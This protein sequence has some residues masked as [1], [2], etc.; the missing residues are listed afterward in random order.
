MP[1]PFPISGYVLAGGRSSRMG[2]DKARIHLAGKPLI[3]H[4]VTKLRRI[5]ANVSILSADH[6]LTRFAPIVPDIHP[7]CGPIGGIE[8]A[9]RHTAHEWNLFLPVDMPFV[10]T[11]LLWNRVAGLLEVSESDPA[12]SPGVRF[13]TIGGRPQPALCLIHQA[14]SPLISEAILGEQQA[15]LA[16]F[17]EVGRRLPGGLANLPLQ[18]FA[19]V[20]G[21]APVCAWPL[22][23]AQSAARELWFLNL[24]TPMG[25]R[26]AEDNASA[27]DT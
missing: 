14:V 10:P 2:R 1:T 13:L 17:E 8:A 16:A 23:S 9:L 20:G 22:T 11:S 18:S 6:M 27:L 3:E 15:L 24:N 12:R 19:S 5:C 26:L 25:H 21:T 7:H 4:A